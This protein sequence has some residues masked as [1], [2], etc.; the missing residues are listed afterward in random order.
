MQEATAIVEENTR[1][2]FPDLQLS[3]D[4]EVKSGQGKTQTSSIY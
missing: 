1:D 2:K 4:T 3:N